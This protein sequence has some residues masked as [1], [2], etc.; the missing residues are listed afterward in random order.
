MT[1]QTMT[2]TCPDCGAAVVWDETD[3]SWVCPECG[4]YAH[5]PRRRKDD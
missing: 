5:E 2:F 3:S 1:R 4:F